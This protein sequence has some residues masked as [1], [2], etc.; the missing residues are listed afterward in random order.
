MAAKF[1]EVKQRRSRQPER[2]EKQNS[3]L[4]KIGFSV[5][6]RVAPSL[7]VTRAM[8]A[9]APAADG[10]AGVCSLSLSLS[11][12]ATG[13]GIWHRKTDAQTDSSIAPECTSLSLSSA[14]L[15]ANGTLRVHSSLCCC[16]ILSSP[17]SPSLSSFCVL[18][19]LPFLGSSNVLPP[20]F[21]QKLVPDQL[22]ADSGGGLFGYCCCCCCR[23]LAP[24][25]LTFLSFPP[26]F[27]TISPFSLSL[28][29]VKR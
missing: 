24:R 9:P 23:F 26:V 16:F 4:P 19:W 22:A 29:A 17:L 21:F 18:F 28:F 7:W 15:G 11:P 14:S 20:S 25:N 6:R 8:N 10:S 2:E 3:L 5:V 12:T 1:D 27:L 13:F